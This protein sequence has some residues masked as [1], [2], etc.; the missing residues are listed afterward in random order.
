M[1]QPEMILIKIRLL[2]A[3]IV[4]GRSAVK[5]LASQL[6]IEQL[7]EIHTEFFNLNLTVFFELEEKRINEYKSFNF[8]RNT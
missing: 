2:V 4:G 3:M 8:G 1:N 6:T 7:K 5:E